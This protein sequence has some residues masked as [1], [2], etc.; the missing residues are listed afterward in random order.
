M[1]RSLEEFKSSFTTDLARA[2]RF[3]ANIYVPLTLFSQLD[4]TSRNLSLRCE[5]AQLP[6][7]TIATMDR[8]TY[9]PIEKLPY[10]STYNDI[11]LTF[12]LDGDMKQKYFFDAWLDKVNP[13]TT[14][15]MNYRDQYSTSIIINQY[16][17]ANK[18][19]Y[20][21]ELIQAYPI[22]INQLDLD[23]G[24]DSPHKLTVTFVYTYWQNNSFFNY[25][26]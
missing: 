2:N 18:L 19:R 24:S 7:R 3:E 11:D 21:V 17:V 12:I 6:G 10:I 14:N 26:I 1:P 15:N 20:S 9:G 16:D 22:S 4:V 23:W 13:K 8:K 5:T 25:I